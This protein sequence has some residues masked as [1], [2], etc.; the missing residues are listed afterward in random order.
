MAEKD[1]RTKL[2]FFEVYA[3][4]A[5][6]GAR[7]VSP[8]RQEILRDDQRHDHVPQV[9]RNDAHSAQREVAEVRRRTRA[10]AA[11]G[12]VAGMSATAW[13]TT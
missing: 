1:A 4:D 9:D 2:T 12:D 8:S 5:A 7:I 3:V 10:A 13:P 6:Y 11:G